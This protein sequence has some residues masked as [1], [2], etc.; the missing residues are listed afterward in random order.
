M[1]KKESKII[2]ASEQ[3]LI[4]LLIM[5]VGGFLFATGNWFRHRVNAL[6]DNAKIKVQIDRSISVSLDRLVVM[7]EKEKKK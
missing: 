4:G 5:L 7:M 3:I 1:K 6:V 2:L